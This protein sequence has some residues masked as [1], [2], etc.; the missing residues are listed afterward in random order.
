MPA[1]FLTLCATSLTCT[2]KILTEEKTCQKYEEKYA[3]ESTHQH[4]HQE[5]LLA[6]LG[7]D[8]GQVPGRR[9]PHTLHLGII[10]NRDREKE[11]I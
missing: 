10:I 11:A 1:P 6:G 9:H 5:A 3:Q 7:E 4:Q 2:T 8:E